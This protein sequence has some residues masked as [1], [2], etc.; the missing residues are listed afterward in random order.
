M[1]AYRQGNLTE[2]LESGYM[3]V[4]W[5]CR[6]PWSSALRHSIA[7]EAASVKIRT[8]K[9]ETTGKLYVYSFTDQTGPSRG[10]ITLV[11]NVLK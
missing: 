2:M 4:R 1:R 7:P 6:L 5:R 10:I 9:S 11:E 8:T 3:V